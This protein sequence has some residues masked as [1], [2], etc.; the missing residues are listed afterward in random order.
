MEKD[1][2]IYGI[3]WQLSKRLLHNEIENIRLSIAE[4]LTVMLAS[5]SLC[6]IC[7]IIVL[8]MFIFLSV[9]IA[10]ML[11]CVMPV[12][13][14]CIVLALFHIVILFAIVIFRRILVID[15]IARF[16]SRLIVEPPDTTNDYGK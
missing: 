6:V 7:A 1:S 16:V 2:R 12:Y 4:R 9:G 10:M 11:S 14:A 13:C 5:V 8:I 15:P 3:I